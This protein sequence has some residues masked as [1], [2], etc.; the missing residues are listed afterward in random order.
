M[1]IFLKNLKKD[2]TEPGAQYRASIEEQARL[3]LMNWKDCIARKCP[4]PIW[5]AGK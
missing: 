1:F 3:F 2:Y 4:H 5:M